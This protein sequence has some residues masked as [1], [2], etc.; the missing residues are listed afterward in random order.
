MAVALSLFA[1]VDTR[2]TAVIVAA[3]VVA[4]V[5]LGITYGPLAALLSELFPARVRYSGASLAYQIGV[6]V[7]GGIAPTVATGLYAT[8]RSSLA[9]TVYL[10]IVCVLSLAC[11]AVIAR[12]TAAS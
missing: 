5:F 4:G 7:G 10:T 8:W 12:R 11:V 3:L 2:S 9:I 6:V 1:L